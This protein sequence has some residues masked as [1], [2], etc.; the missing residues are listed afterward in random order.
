MSKRL[1]RIP[2]KNISSDLTN[3]DGLELNAI[4]RTGNTYFGKLISV[5]NH[6]LTML[7]KRQHIHKLAIQ[8]LY[9]V[10][11]DHKEKK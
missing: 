3:V 11:Y 2:S 5:T 1:I 10:V 9:E 6:Y 4:L 7:D 8:D